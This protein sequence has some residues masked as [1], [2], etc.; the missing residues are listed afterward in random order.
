MI[1]VAL[2]LVAPYVAEEMWEQLGHPPSVAQATL[3]G[4]RPQ[5]WW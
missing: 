3:A 4:R 2:S 5:S 1:T